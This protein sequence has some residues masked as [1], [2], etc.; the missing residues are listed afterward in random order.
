MAFYYLGTSALVK[1]YVQ[2][3]GA[4]RLL[5]LVSAEPENRLAVLAVSVVEL[6]SA[7]RRRQRAGDID[8]DTAAAML[9]SVQTHMETRFILTGDQ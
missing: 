5:T 7:I 1:L 6:R 8:A 3:P 9:E 2:E 4:D